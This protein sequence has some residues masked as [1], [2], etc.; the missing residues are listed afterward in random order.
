VHTPLSFG[1]ANI[2][3]G[4]G[5]LMLAWFL[6]ARI[7]IGTVANAVL[8]G[9]Y[10]QLLLSIDAVGELAE[11]PLGPRL[12]LLGAG[13]LLMGLGSG[14]YIGA[15]LGAGPRDSLM[16]VGSRRTGVRIGIV[17]TAIELAALGV[18]WALGGTVGIGTVAFALLIGP[19][20]E[21][22]FGLLRRT[23]LVRAPQAAP[24]AA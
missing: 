19:S 5:V 16:L 1:E 22:S 13:I 14:F 8:I 3:V 21:L 20:V 4:L 23:P 10:I 7:G 9:V 18:G 15:D 24:A 17:R 2:V 12:G 6:G 11:W